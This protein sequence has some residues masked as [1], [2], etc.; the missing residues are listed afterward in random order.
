MRMGKILGSWSTGQERFSELLKCGC[1]KK[2]WNLLMNGAAG[3]VM[4]KRKFNNSSV[5]QNPCCNIHALAEYSTV[6]VSQLMRDIF[7]LLT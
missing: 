5:P 1:K 2:E 6:P 4:G 3:R 7:D